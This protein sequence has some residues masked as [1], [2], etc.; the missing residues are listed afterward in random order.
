VARLISGKTYILEPNPAA[1]ETV[2]FEFD[3]WSEAT[4]SFRGNGLPLV[5]PLVGLDGLYRFSVA[6]D[7][8][9]VA[10]R[11]AWIDAQTFFL[12]Y[13]GITRNDHSLFRFRFEG[14]Q[15]E[16]A[17]QETAHEAVAQFVGQLQQP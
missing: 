6:P 12:E 1:L 4:F 11:G 5:S 10:F 17:V 13:D 8:R 16:V 7:G 3:G 9:P 15:V 2:A 14:D